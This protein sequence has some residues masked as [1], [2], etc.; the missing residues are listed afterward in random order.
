MAKEKHHVAPQSVPVSTPRPDVEWYRQ[1]P[2]CWNSL[3]GVGVA[4]KTMPTENMVGTRY[5]KC[6]TCG[7]SFSRDF[8]VAYEVIT[9][10]VV[11][12][13]RR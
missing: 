11:N 5:Y 6:D 13:I 1:C 8:E 3:G 7:T 4:Y 2:H 12:V 10:R 9:K